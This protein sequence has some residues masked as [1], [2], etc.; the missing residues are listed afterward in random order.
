MQIVTL[1]SILIVLTLPADAQES[2][3]SILKGLIEEDIQE[4]GLTK[5]DSSNNLRTYRIWITYQQVIEVSQL[6]NSTFSGFVINYITKTEGRGKRERNELIVHNSPIPPE[7][8]MNLMNDLQKENIE[9][10]PDDDEVEE[11]PDGLDG[12][13]YTFE[14]QTSDKHRLYSYWEPMND[15]YTN[16]Q[17]PEVANVRNIIKRLNKEFDLWNHF[18][19]FR[20]RLPSGN[21]SYGGIQMIKM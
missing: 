5:L 9:T 6:D 1:I 8:I 16:E 19:K 11:Y 7:R 17:T 21:Y 13:S 18:V 4:L 15:R 10:L 14:V 3:Q 2:K 20:D 12:T